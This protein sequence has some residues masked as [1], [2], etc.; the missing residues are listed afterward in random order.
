MINKKIFRDRYLLLLIE[1]QLDEL[2]GAEIFSTLDLRNGFFHVA[3]EESSR[4]YTAF[5]IPDGQ[6]EFLKVPFGLCN[7]PSVFQRFICAVFKE[8][9]AAKVVLTY[10]DDLIIP[11]TDYA[12]GLR[13][14]ELVLRTASEC[15]LLLN[16]EKCR[17]LQEEVEYLG[18]KVKR[19]RIRPSENKT[20]AVMRFPEPTNVKQV[21]GFLSLKGY[22]RKFIPRYSLIARPLTDLLKE[23][24]EFQF[25]ARE[26]EAFQ[27]LK[28]ILSDQPVLRLYNV[29]AY[30][31]LHTDAC[32][33]GYGS[34]LL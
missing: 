10:M 9:I 34:I 15:G 28:A 17:F 22:F 4:K 18:Y 32:V 25:A 12:S 8:L 30:T 14:L 3:L 29:K 6:Y 27:Q 24:V 11:S 2:Q 20:N 16:W 1:D 31:E 13:S 33:Y 26:R 5:V 19:G 21:Q 7:S 23:N